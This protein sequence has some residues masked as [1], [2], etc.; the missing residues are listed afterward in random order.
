MG[1]I[2]CIEAPREGFVTFHTN[3]GAI[4]N[5]SPQWSWWARA[6]EGSR[7][8]FF[9]MYC[10]KSLNNICSLYKTVGG[11]WCLFVFMQPVKKK[12]IKREIKILDN[13]RGGPNIISLLDVVKDPWVSVWCYE[14]TYERF[15]LLRTSLQSRTPALIFEHVDNT[16]FKVHSTSQTIDTIDTRESLI[17]KFCFNGRVAREWQ[18]CESSCLVWFEQPYISCADRFVFELGNLR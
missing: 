5:Y 13:L 16:D 8:A 4:M 10:N 17:G 11:R 6:K 15:Q 18:L 2:S 9:P 12:K 14:C 3:N 7:T 1:G